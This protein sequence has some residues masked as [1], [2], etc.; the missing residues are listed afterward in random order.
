VQEGD[1]IF[2]VPTHASPSTVGELRA[3]CLSHDE[4][5]RIL[6]TDLEERDVSDEGTEACV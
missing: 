1:K 4:L 5:F 2:L 6:K 3:L